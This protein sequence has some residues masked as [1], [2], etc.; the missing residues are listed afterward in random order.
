MASM[1]VSASAVKAWA[2]AECVG[3]FHRK[4]LQQ[5]HDWPVAFGVNT[6][7]NRCV[8]KENIWTHQKSKKKT[9]LNSNVLLVHRAT[10]PAIPNLERLLLDC[11]CWLFNH[12]KRSKKVTVLSHLIPFAFSYSGLKFRWVMATSSCHHQDHPEYVIA[13]WTAQVINRSWST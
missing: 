13:C 1:V 10:R 12:Q 8:K 11:C 6:P 9:Q 3:K 4:K 2:I 7:W 5:R